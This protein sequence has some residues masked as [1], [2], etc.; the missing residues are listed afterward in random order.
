MYVLLLCV[1]TVACAGGGTPSGGAAGSGAAESTGGAGTSGGAGAIGGA[2]A[3]GV[4]GSTGV[5]G[6]SGAGSN[7]TQ[8]PD[9]GA[10]TGAPDGG[11]PTTAQGP[12]VLMRSYDLKRTGANLFE[13]T[14]SPANVAAAT[15]GKRACHTVDGEI[16]GQILFLPGFD[17][18]AKG[19]HDAL[20]VATMRNRIY[21]LDADDPT[22]V[23]WSKSYGTPAGP[24]ATLATEGG[25]ST[26]RPYNDVS[27]WVGILSTPT[28]DP[29]TGTLFFVARTN[30]GGQQV[31]KLY[32]QSLVDGT[33]RPGSPV[34]IAATYAGTGDQK[35][36]FKDTVTNGRFAFNSKRQNQRMA[37]TL[38]GGI[39]YIGWS[40][41]CDLGAFHGW[42]IGYDAKT[43]QQAVVFNTTPNGAS[44]GIWMSGSGPAVDDDGTLY[45]ATGNGT[46]DLQGGANHGESMLK[47]RRQGATLEV[48]DWFV[49]FEYD[50]LE[51]RDR[52]LGSAGV[53]LVPG[54]N[55]LMAGGKDAKI[56]VTD[57]MNMGKFTPPTRPYRQPGSGSAEV[58]PI[59]TDAVVQTL[60]VASMSTPPR[61]HNHSTPVYW[62]SD[63]GEFVYTMAE[64]DFLQQWRLVNGRFEL[65][66]SSQVRAPDDPMAAND[67][68]MPGGTMALSAD[69]AKSA[70]GIVWVTMPVSK[71]AN[72]A[73]V[74]G[75]MY[76][77]A[78]AD[79]SKTLWSSQD[80]PTRDAVGNYAK[81][82]PVTVYDGRVYVPTFKNPEATNQFCVYGLR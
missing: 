78:A 48:L 33:D 5:A 68:T 7:G 52:D 53:L 32:A 28:V 22:I 58:L 63:A 35:S 30:E 62:K 45:L 79:V 17:F 47:L 37:L 9:G 39:V 10:G 64:E 50:F 15:F 36:L 21:V 13:S 57:K 12:G 76:A 55:L 43:L 24:A 44:G 54:T 40:A 38:A 25:V 51:Y 16:Y 82:N 73:V 71:D 75:A 1:G 31:Q 2:G 20:V 8:P 74:P 23:L 60:A 80:D 4:A 34:T 65:Y 14:L 61:A 42:L 77:F 6:S 72:N 11:V 67:Y 29:Q 19:R 59:G 56:Y 18:G 3:N 69:G 66:K 70:S 26:C 46:A 81:F 49:P 27:Q 41:F